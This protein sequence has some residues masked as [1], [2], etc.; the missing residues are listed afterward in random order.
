[1]FSRNQVPAKVEQVVNS[2]MNAQETLSLPRRF[3]PSHTPFSNSCW[4]MR[5]LCPV[6]G[7]LRCIVHRVGDQFSMCNAVASQLIRDDLSGLA[8]IFSEQPFEEPLGCCTV[9]S[10]L[11][12]HIDHLSVLIHGSPQVLLPTL[13]LHEHFIDEKCVSISLMSTLQA[14]D[15]FG[16][17]LVAPQSNRLIAYCNTAFSQQILDVSMAKVESVIEPNGVLNDFRGETMSLIQ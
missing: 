6:I 10:H 7:I 1:M 16:A 14:L 9:T 3:K 13:D 17:E 8:A 12:K 5:K 4:L 15:I 2:R 11:Q